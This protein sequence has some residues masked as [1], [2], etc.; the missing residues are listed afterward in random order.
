MG[1]NI[2]NERVCALARDVARRT[3]QTQTSAI[4]SALE[5]YLRDLLAQDE[6]R[7]ERRQ[8]EAA[9]RNRRVDAIVSTFH[10]APRSERTVAEL[11]DELYDPVTGLPR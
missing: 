9:Q 11:M 6:D 7:R 4:E 2:K 1:L 3:G 10:A 5:A 8:V